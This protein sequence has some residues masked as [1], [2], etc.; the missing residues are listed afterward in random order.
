M[1]YDGPAASTSASSSSPVDLF[2]A[3][4]E[5]LKLAS[6]LKGEEQ[7][8]YLDAETGLAVSWQEAIARRWGRHGNA[9]GRNENRD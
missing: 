2:A 8:D 6:R 5:P 4:Y 1:D 7:L 9:D 3:F